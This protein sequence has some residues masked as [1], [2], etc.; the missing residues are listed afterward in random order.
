MTVQR[1][2]GLGI[3]PRSPTEVGGEWAATER[4]ANPDRAASELT[5]SLS[6]PLNTPLPPGTKLRKRAVPHDPRM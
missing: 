4:R 5:P 6:L 2:M 1:T 3:T